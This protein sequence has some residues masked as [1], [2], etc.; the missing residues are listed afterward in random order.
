MGSQFSRHTC[1]FSSL[2][3]LR[4]AMFTLF[5][6]QDSMPHPSPGQLLHLLLV[7]SKSRPL[8]APRLGVSISQR[9]SEPH[10]SLQL[11]SYRISLTPRRRDS[12]HGHVIIGG[13]GLNGQALGDAWVSKVS[14][15]D[16]GWRSYRA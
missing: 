6:I 14:S 11:A 2:L 16:T 7:S 3:Q 5:F 8:A 1:E 15:I 12:R 10:V 4:T 13:K 9:A